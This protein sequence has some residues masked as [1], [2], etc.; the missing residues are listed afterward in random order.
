MRSHELVWVAGLLECLPQVEVLDVDV[1]AYADWLSDSKGGG[2]LVPTVDL[3]VHVDGMADAQ[4]LVEA[5][6]LREDESRLRDHDGTRWHYWTGWSADASR[7][8]A[9]QVE[10][11]AA[12]LLDAQA[13][14]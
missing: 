8:A 1:R 9:V 2:S 7:Q 10:V 6:R 11:I 3:R 14:A 12:E 4:L 5:L 13:V